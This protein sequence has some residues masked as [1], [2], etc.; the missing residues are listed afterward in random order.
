M[1]KEGTEM[2]ADREIIHFTRERNIP[3]I[4]ED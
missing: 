3:E 1:K 4:S 2:T